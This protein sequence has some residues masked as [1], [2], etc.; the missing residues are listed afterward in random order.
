MC[1]VRGLPVT[2]SQLDPNYFPITTTINNNDDN[3]PRFESK[4]RGDV[5]FCFILP[6]FL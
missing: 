6:L 1:I 4:I 2:K 5:P 3:P